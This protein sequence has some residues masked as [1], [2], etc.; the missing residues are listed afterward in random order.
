MALRHS[1]V[2]CDKCQ[3]AVMSSVG[4]I[5][6]FSDQLYKGVK[7]YNTFVVTCNNQQVGELYIV[8]VSQ[9]HAYINMEGAKEKYLPI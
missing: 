8:A 1:L 4:G 3:T 7:A 9:A 6:L 2:I 5:T